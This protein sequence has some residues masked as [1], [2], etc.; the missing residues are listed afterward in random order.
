M[1]KHRADAVNGISC[2]DGRP[3][4]TSPDAAASRCQ[5]GRA[6]RLGDSDGSGLVAPIGSSRHNDACRASTGCSSG[7]TAVVA[8]VVGGT[9]P[10]VAFLPDPSTRVSIDETGRRIVMKG[11]V[12]KKGARWYAVIY[13]GIDCVTGHAIR[14]RHNLC[15][16]L[17]PR[18]SCRCALPSHASSQT[19]VVEA[20]Y[21]GPSTPLFFAISSVVAD[22]RRVAL[23][24]ETRL[25]RTTGYGSRSRTPCALSSAR[26]D[27][28][29]TV[30]PA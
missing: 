14:A 15:C 6:V 2:A 7:E 12:A 5:T 11:Y 4:H 8:E 13:E 18:T 30:I 25:T 23:P 26:L 9:L 19:E 20:I 1:M 10:Q 16:G 22:Q 21:P 27:A 29:R 24:R 3:G 28:E 17:V